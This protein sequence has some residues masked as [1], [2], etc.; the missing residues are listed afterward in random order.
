MAV[1]EHERDLGLAAVPLAAFALAQPVVRR[2][3][4]VIRR[5]RLVPGLAQVAKLA[6]QLRPDL[7]VK[8]RGRER[9]IRRARDREPES[10]TT[11]PLD[12]T[13]DDAVRWL[14]VRHAGDGIYTWSWSF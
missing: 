7:V 11:H 3:W 9:R 4:Q 10:G 5:G 8:C 6:V 2:R 12:G 14:S 13:N 1:A